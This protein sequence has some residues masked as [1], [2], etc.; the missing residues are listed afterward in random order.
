MT[1]ILIAT[2]TMVALTA[3]GPAEDCD[4][5]EPSP[6]TATVVNPS[7]EETSALGEVKGWEYTSCLW[8]RGVEASTYESWQGVNSLA[9]TQTG[10]GVFQ[11][12]RG[13]NIYEASTYKLKLRSVVETDRTEERPEGCQNEC[14][15]VELRWYDENGALDNSV[16]YI[17]LIDP[18]RPAWSKNEFTGTIPM[19][20]RGLTMVF[21]QAASDNNV[22]AYLDDVEFTFE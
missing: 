3:C 17:G 4:H 11:R 6:T 9:L 5:N 16:H 2:L 14:V 8:G 18:R 7:F 13:D 12:L 19:G 22:R 10:C 15:R 20:A 21:V 1:R